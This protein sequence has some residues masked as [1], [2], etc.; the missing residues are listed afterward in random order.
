M[1]N[2]NT[3]KRILK[4]TF[5]TLRVLLIALVIYLIMLFFAQKAIIYPGAFFDN[6]NL[7]ENTVL[8][9]EPI[10]LK[11]TDNN[12]VLLYKLAGKKE[13]NK[14]LLIFHGNAD[15]ATN[16]MNRL[17][18]PYVLHNGY[19]IYGIEYRGFQGMPGLPSEETLLEDSK[20]VLN[21]IKEQK[22]Y[23]T[24]VY[25][26]HSLGTGIA[27]NLAGYYIPD[28]L[29]LEAPF[30]SLKDMASSLY[31]FI[32]RMLI[33]LMVVESYDSFKTLQT[34]E[35]PNL[36]ILNAKDDH[37]IPYKQGQSLYDIAISPNK[38]F[39]SYDKG[40][41][42]DIYLFNDTST[43]RDFLLKIN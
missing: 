34:I 4:Y 36:L 30:S 31:P 29:V 9:L 11:S 25:Y 39:K 16:I 21:Y 2:T 27:V 28:G 15:S 7:S 38:I 37:V 1:N 24:L 5:R 6:P 33:N 10:N 17:Y 22:K 32:P 41:H 8:Q 14:A 26:G 12:P 35:V 3:K 20:T 40:G 18:N 13:N 42:S 43:L 23:E 19:D